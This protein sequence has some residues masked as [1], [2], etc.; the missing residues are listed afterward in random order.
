MDKVQIDLYAED[1]QEDIWEDEYCVRLGVSP[2]VKA[3]RI[4]VEDVK[5]LR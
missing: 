4:T 3:I 2:D 5:V 1:F